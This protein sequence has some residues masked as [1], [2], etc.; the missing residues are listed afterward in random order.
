M[1]K[2]LENLIPVDLNSE[3][4]PKDIEALQLRVAVQ[5][6]YSLGVLVK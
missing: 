4:K 5:R 6:K 1:S 2:R 3:E